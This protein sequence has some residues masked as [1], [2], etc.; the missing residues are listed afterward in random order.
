ME[1]YYCRYCKG[2]HPKF[3]GS[4]H[5][6]L[7]AQFK[8][9]QTKDINVSF[10]GSSPPDIFVGKYNYP[11]V[12][13][14]I[15]SPV[16]HD[17]NAKG[18]SDPEEWFK[19]KLSSDDILLKRSSLIYSRFENSVKN[20]S[21]RL[22]DVMQ[23][24]SMA[25]KSCDVEFNLKK[26]PKIRVNTDAVTGPL[27]NVAPLRKAKIIGNVKVA[28]KVDYF[29]DDHHLKAENAIVDLHKSGFSVSSMIKLLSAG[30]LGIKHQRRLV[31]SRWSTTAVDDMVS[32]NL[33]KKVRDYNW[34]NDFIVFSDEYLGNHYEILLLPRNWSFEVIEAKIG[35][36]KFW[37]DYEINFKRKKYASDVT[38]A[39]Y[40]NRL[41]VVEYLNKIKRQASVIF[42]REIRNYE[43]PLGVGILR[44]V[45]R[46]AF[47]KKCRR[48]NT[49][50]E[51]LEDMGSRM[52]S[53]INNY[54]S[55]SKVIREYKKQLSLREFLFCKS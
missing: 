35:V 37:Q 29:V 33:L 26:S 50:K 20:P 46:G 22:N 12:F 30:L 13:S 45:S 31:P 24:I 49:L 14:G 18:M 2:W 41:A 44:E 42:F 8:L 52:K 36:G 55:K 21:G 43:V 1:G 53:P 48:F 47:N 6:P 54:I 39:Y 15:L 17:D 10:S 51:A 19:N 7:Q 9:F 34:V 28:R 5:C 16:G 25:Y 3:Y 27:G 11:N 4:D 23:E 32:R 38:G 40:A